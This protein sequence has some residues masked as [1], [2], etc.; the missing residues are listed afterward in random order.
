MYFHQYTIRHVNKIACL[1]FIS[2]GI[3]SCGSSGSGGD[4]SP[5]C[6]P[7]PPLPAETKSIVLT[8]PDYLS[9]SSPD[10]INGDITYAFDNWLAR[11]NGV[12]VYD[13]STG[14]KGAKLGEFTIVSNVFQVVMDVPLA[15]SALLLESRAPCNWEQ[16]YLI[17]T[18]FFNSIQS[19]G[20]YSTGDYV[21]HTDVV[22]MK[23]V[24]TADSQTVSF[25]PF[26]HAATGLAEYRINQG[27]SVTTAVT[28]SNN[29]VSSMVG[30][31]ILTTD[32]ADTPDDMAYIDSPDVFYTMLI[33]GFADVIINEAASE[34]VAISLGDAGYSIAELAELMR[35]DLVADGV[36]NGVE[37][38]SAPVLLGGFIPLST[39]F[40]RHKLAVHAST[41]ARVAGY[42]GFSVY[43]NL[44]HIVA[45]NSNTNSI[46]D[47]SP[48][49]ALDENG[50][51][52]GFSSTDVAFFAAHPNVDG[53]VSFTV[54]FGDSVG[55]YDYTFRDVFVDN[56][57]YAN[58]CGGGSTSTFDCWVN[59]TIFPN[60]WHT[61]KMTFTNLL[62][63]SASL[64]ITVNFQN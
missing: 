6:D 3:I 56:V 40:Y 36:L 49:I 54:H 17:N 39:N 61:V 18:N 14:S 37:I 27:D 5:C 23:S 22:N 47:S 52:I 38:A 31:N 51:L 63:H 50:P 64:S 42:D 62:G 59:T 29:I 2:L 7:L 44:S 34:S 15:T 1:V 48:V 55:S 10:G 35:R 4:V 19:F 25:T 28:T 43:Q 20:S 12:S 8:V 32:T 11:T 46:Y 60:G 58:T 24:I 30:V 45:F 26:T 41:N 9:S 53:T 21:C 33:S 57:F 13:F 16:G